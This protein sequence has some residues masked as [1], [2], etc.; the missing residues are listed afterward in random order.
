MRVK[1]L[2]T[3]NESRIWVSGWS[4]YR[5]WRRLG[6]RHFNRLSMSKRSIR[7]STIK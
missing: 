7:R 2:G 4:P 1:V 6:E 3:G 5:I